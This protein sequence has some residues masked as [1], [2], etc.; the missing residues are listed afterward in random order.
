MAAKKK[1]GGP[2]TSFALPIER[3]DPA[4]GSDELPQ[5]RKLLFTNWLF[6]FLKKNIKYVPRTSHTNA[7]GTL[8]H[9]V[10]TAL[11][12]DSK[13]AAYPLG[14]AGDGADLSRV[15][16]HHWLELAIAGLAEKRSDFARWF[17]AFGH[18]LGAHASVETLTAPGRP[19]PLVEVAPPRKVL[20][21][22]VH[23]EPDRMIAD[24]GVAPPFAE[25]GAADRK[26]LAVAAKTGLCA[27]FL[28]AKL[29]G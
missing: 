9:W 7:L 2:A 1:R 26:V 19:L 29:R 20:V 14:E 23:G 12:Q 22:A 10:T 25:L 5:L 6:P 17:S 27:C 13:D 4:A 15:A 18:R 28:C 24:E 3:I 8:E 21:A 11:Q 16:A